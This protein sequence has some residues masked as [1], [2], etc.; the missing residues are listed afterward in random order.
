MAFVLLFFLVFSI[1]SNTFDASWQFDDHQNIIEDVNIRVKDLGIKSLWKSFFVASKEKI[2]RP[3]S[4]VTF[5]V[6]WYFSKT[7]VTGY[8][9]VNIFIHLL[10]GCILFLTV[11]ALLRTPAVRDKYRDSEHFIALLTAVFWAINPVQTQAVTYIVQRM[12]SMAAMFYIL[13]MFFYLKGRSGTSR[14]KKYLFFLGCFLSFLFGLASKENVMI[15]PIALVLVEMTF[16]QDLGQKKTRRTLLWVTVGGGLFLVFISSLLFFRGNALWTILEGYEN[17]F[18]TPMQRLMT[19]PRVL[20]FYVSQ[21][22]YPVP[23]RLSMEHDIL[24]STSLLKPWTTL[25]SIG[26]VLSLIAFSL[27]KIRKMPIISFAILFYFLNHSIE[28]T[29]LD[30]E[31][32]FEHRNYLPSLFIFLPVSIGIRHVFDYYHVKKPF[33][34]YTLVSFLILLLVGLG[35]GTYIRNMAWATERSLWGDAME[36]APGMMRP[37]HNVAWTYKRSAK[38]E[39]AIELY[40]KALKL[41]MHTRSHGAI[42]YNNMAAIYYGKK[43]YE[44]AVELW[45]KASEINPDFEG[46]EY[47]IALALTELGHWER[48]SHHLDAVLK[49][50]PTYYDF[51]M[52]KGVILLNKKRP[53]EAV[54]YFRKWMKEYPDDAKARFYLGVAFDFLGDYNKAEIFFKNAKPNEFATLLHLINVNL[55]MGDSK[56]VDHYFGMLFGLFSLN[57][58]ETKL[59]QNFEENFLDAVSRRV[60]AQEIASKLREKSKEIA[61]SGKESNGQHKNDK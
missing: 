12:A 45:K 54:S 10:T 33:M 5:A 15:L 21:I 47:R 3:F 24:I 30:L 56:D 39:K 18:F 19:E 41:K 23:T 6:N 22:F 49:K 48:A 52:L 35:S 61:K 11:V 42:P 46:Y 43:N 36:K 27:W 31:L 40:E 17:R 59:K 53:I 16:F 8:H 1:Y 9:I 44:K 28:S 34:F 14:W 26:L 57:E 25:P 38:Y 50:R 7:D 29:I 37:V 2:S 20:I 4:R 51:L 55:K 60:L 58:L 13:S 32:I